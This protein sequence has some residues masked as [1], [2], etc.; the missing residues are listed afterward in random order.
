ML[1][2]VASRYPERCPALPGIASRCQALLRVTPHCLALPRS[3]PPCLTL[4]GITPLNPWVCVV[5]DSNLQHSIQ[6][7]AMTRTPNPKL[8]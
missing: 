6:G 1:Y 2:R 8:S 7:N 4:P 5:I 3:A